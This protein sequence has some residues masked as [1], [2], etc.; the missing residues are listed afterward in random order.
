MA[1]VK[2]DLRSPNAESGTTTRQYA[3]QND[4]PN[5]KRVIDPTNEKLT[6]E[7]IERLAFLIR[8]GTFSKKYNT[9]YYEGYNIPEFCK[10][11]IKELKWKPWKQW[12]TFK[13]VPIPARDE[14]I[15]YISESSS[16]S[17]LSNTS[18]DESN[19][20][21]DKIRLGLNLM[22]RW[23]KQ[24]YGKLFFNS[25]ENIRYKNIIN[26]WRRRKAFETRNT[27]L[28]GRQKIEMAR[29]SLLDELPY[30][31]AESLPQYGYGRKRR[32]RKKKRNKKTRKKW[33]SKYKKSI[34]CKNPKGFSQKQYC[35]YG[36]KTR[37][38]KNNRKKTRRRKR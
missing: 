16:S 17:M 7:E 36:R 3:L 34:D 28:K 22:D 26:D 15:N 13:D 25:H 18:G 33:S 21:I 14:I 6:D 30:Y 2:Y 24:K 29:N 35:K 20:N 38:Q 10:P 12:K 27:A 1:D 19:E 31:K 9:S 23:E 4:F 8:Q 5:F 11:A 32:T 37:R